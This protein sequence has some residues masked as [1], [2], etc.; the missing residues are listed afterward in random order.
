MVRGAGLPALFVSR[1]MTE[2]SLFAEVLAIA[3]PAARARFLD[4]ACG[5]HPEL[6]RGVE[7]LLAAHTRSN[8]LDQP[9]V[10][11]ANLTENY[12]PPPRAQGTILAGRYKLLE[13]IGVGGMGEVWVAEQ[14]EPVKRKVALKLI[15]PGMDSRA[16][17]ARFEAE[18][19]ALA[20]MNHPSIASVFDGGLTDLGRPFF[21]MEYVKGVP[22][23]EY[24][25]TMRLPVAERL[26]LFLRV[27]HAVQHAHQK[28]VIHRDLKPS[29][30]LV[31]PYDGKPVPKVIDFG[32]AKAMH[33]PLTEK[34]L[35]TGHET[36]LGTPLYMSPEQAQ[37]NNLDVDTRSDIY[38]L[39]VLLYELLTGTTPLDRQRFKAAAWEEICRLIREEE[40][41]R[42]SAR[43]SST[44]TLPSLAASRQTEPV[45]LTKLLRGELDWIV[46][47]ALDKERGRRYGS[48]NDFAADV[49]RYIAGDPVVAAPP[50]VG[51]RLRKFARKHRRLLVTGTAFAI[52]LLVATAISLWLALRATQAEAVAD[53]ARE[54]AVADSQRAIKARDREVKARHEVVLAHAA[55]ARSSERLRRILYASDLNHVA[56]AWHADQPQ[57]MVDLLERHRPQKG[58]DDLRGF[59]WHYWMRKLHGES[60]WVALEN[61]G[62]AADGTDPR[63]RTGAPMFSPSGRRCVLAWSSAD[64]QGFHLRVWNTSSGKLLLQALVVSPDVPWRKLVVTDYRFTPD[65]TRLHIPCFETVDGGAVPLQVVLEFPTGQLLYRVSADELHFHPDNKRAMS[66]R[67]D[68][69]QRRLAWHDAA[70]GKE[71]KAFAPDGMEQPFFSKNL[72]RCAAIHGAGVGDQREVRVY[73]TATGAVCAKLPLPEP[74]SGVSLRFSPD[75][76]RLV[77]GPHQFLKSMLPGQPRD[78]PAAILMWDLDAAK[79][80]WTRFTTLFDAGTIF[81]PDG[82]KCILLG[83]HADPPIL[84]DTD[85]QIKEVVFSGVN[86]Y[87]LNISGME[88][89]RLPF[90]QDG[91]LMVCWKPQGGFTIHS[92]ATGKL[93]F[94][95]RFPASQMRAAFAV[96]DAVLLA[97][98]DSGK[99]RHWATR[100]WLRP[101]GEAD[102]PDF[103]A[104][105]ALLDPAG[106]TFFACE[107]VSD[108][109]LIN[110]TVKEYDARDGRLVRTVGTYSGSQIGLTPLVRRRVIFA[111]FGPE[112]IDAITLI[113]FASGR[114]QLLWKRGAEKFTEVPRAYLLE[115][116]RAIL[117]FP[118]EANPFADKQDGNLFHFWWGSRL[119]VVDLQTGAK[120]PSWMDSQENVEL[121]SPSLDGKKIALLRHVGGPPP[122]GLRELVLADLETGHVFWTVFWT[123][124]DLGFSAREIVF[125]PQSRQLLVSGNGPRGAII[126]VFDT[127]HGDFICPLH[128]AGAKSTADISFSPDG[129]RI[130]GAAYEQLGI[131]GLGQGAYRLWDA[132]TGLELAAFPMGIWTGPLQFDAKGQRLIA[133]RSNWRNRPPGHALHVLDGT[134]LP[135]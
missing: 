50:R 16:V 17:L 34:T 97:V 55:L 53:Q 94:E 30:I 120:I 11:A 84:V 122:K 77:L 32:L 45:K 27:C 49:E 47:K 106:D 58:E 1:I 114:Q 133:L 127:K 80:L 119:Q 130:V 10:I 124:G 6:R 48:A 39:G 121:C 109:D 74:T 118:A 65:E 75:G 76:K 29:N 72:E 85:T 54:E 87:H 3:D 111:R 89:G 18:R 38:S 64:K 22:I 52:M 88:R 68:K 36:V 98:D 70:T 57:R 116:D 19:Q 93:I 113:D 37:L 8:L 91:A 126:H 90:S 117:H 104:F 105:Q 129:K 4:H 21:V 61:H 83:E 103:A 12:A 62:P 92:T 7:A 73:D 2:E 134:P 82:K 67:V 71:S 95:A 112:F 23:T 69:G 24:C 35:H 60:R 41:P 107:P 135:E 81:T 131:V 66:T 123:M 99:V 25:D 56:I 15:K 26:Q 79:L 115:S 42:P 9:A 59:E 5:G 128:L 108:K 100:D 96:D 125:C 13:K 86:S 20:L 78:K 132:S 102:Q 51:Y 40:P 43:L 28:G 44:A 14:L 63:E 31:A 33:Q 110:T 101:D 46:M